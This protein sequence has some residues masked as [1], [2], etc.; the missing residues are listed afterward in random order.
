MT[1][2][3]DGRELSR[4]FPMPSGPVVAL[5]DVSIEIAPGEYVA[6]TG[7]SGCGKSTLLHLLG[8]VDAPTSGSLRF[9]GRDVATLG[10]FERSRIRLTRIGF[11]FQRFFLLPMLDA[12]EN[13]ELPQAEMGVG[14]AARRDRTRELLDYVGL[15]DGAR[16]RPSQLSG[17]EMQRV[18]IARALAN[19]PA[20]LLAD[21]P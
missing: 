19:R 11:V 14:L 7:P 9:E 5:R 3:V 12:W 21:E 4:T 20:L 18:A 16:H 8:C 17:G 15:A 13:V 6:I 10:E 2:I 1:P